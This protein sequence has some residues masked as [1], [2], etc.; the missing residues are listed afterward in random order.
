M[1]EVCV[2][3]G[4]AATARVDDLPAAE[5]EAVPVEEVQES[6]DGEN[7]GCAFCP[8]G[9]R[10]EF[11]WRVLGQ[12]VLIYAGWTTNHRGLRTGVKVSPSQAWGRDLGNPAAATRLVLELTDDPRVQ[13]LVGAEKG[14]TVHA[15]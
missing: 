8:C 15:C 12:S 14:S 11:I 2:K 5:I 4:D 3:E 9:R 13:S 7:G 6:G 1:D 10:R